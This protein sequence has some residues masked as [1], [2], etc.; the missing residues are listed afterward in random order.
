MT[1]ENSEPL[2]RS[3]VYELLAWLWAQ[4]PDGVLKQLDQEPLASAWRGMGGII[5]DVTS[6]AVRSS[7][8]EEYCRL[9]IGPSGHLPPMQSVWMTGE[10]DKG[11]KAS[12]SEFDAVVDFTPPWKFTT[13]PDHIGNQLW[14]M[15]QILRK[16]VGLSNTECRLAEDLASQ[17]FISHLSWADPLLNAVIDRGGDGFYGTIASIT[18][19]FLEDESARFR[20][21]AVS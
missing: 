10:L 11:V 19:N 16:S 20:T 1:I 7:L 8:D 2:Q 9:F 14:A 4:E 21:A 18:R 6:D 3:L 12:L 13:M 15:G 17:F 5:P